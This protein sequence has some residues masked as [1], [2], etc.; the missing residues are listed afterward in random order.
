[1]RQASTKSRSPPWRPAFFC[2]R[3]PWLALLCGGGLWCAGALPVAGCGHVVPDPA[4]LRALSTLSSTTLATLDALMSEV[5][6]FQDPDPEAWRGRADLHF[7]VDAGISPTEWLCS[8]FSP[9]LPPDLHATPRTR[10]LMFDMLLRA[11]VQ[12]TA[13]LNRPGGHFRVKGASLVAGTMPRVA[14]VDLDSQVWIVPDPDFD[15]PL[16]VTHLF[17][18]SFHG[19]G[20]AAEAI[21]QLVGLD[22]QQEIMVDFSPQVVASLSVALDVP[23]VLPVN[24]ASWDPTSTQAVILADVADRGLL[25]C[26]PWAGTHVATA[27]PPCPPWSRAGE[28]DGLGD[29]HGMSFVTALAWARAAAPLALLMEC[30]DGLPEHPHFPIIL[31]LVQWAGYRVHHSLVHDHAT[32]GPCARRRWLATLLRYDVE[33]LAPVPT[34]TF[35]DPVP[36]P[37][38]HQD[39]QVQ[40]APEMDLARLLDDQV[41]RHYTNPAFLP[42]AEPHQHSAQEVLQR[43]LALDDQPLRTLCAR[44]SQQHVLAAATLADRGLFAQLTLVEFS[45]LWLGAVRPL[46]LPPTL[47]EVFHGLGNCISVPQAAIPWTV[48]LSAVGLIAEVPEHLVLRVWRHRLRGVALRPAVVR[49]WYFLGALDQLIDFAFHPQ[50]PVRAD[51]EGPPIVVGDEAFPRM[52]FP[53][54]MGAAR[55]TLHSPSGFSVEVTYPVGAAVSLVLLAA[56]LPPVVLPLLAVSTFARVWLPRESAGDLTGHDLA[57]VPAQEPGQLAPQPPPPVLVPPEGLH[58]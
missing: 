20:Q 3:P 11:P 28:Q 23:C 44:Y 12:F 36:V 53:Y 14:L 22:I 45:L 40:E 21:R 56:R 37:W 25:H 43:R 8:A 57:V 38:T 47:E 9:G 49:G 42:G 2:A 17:A 51:A 50:A 7:R 41:L 19:W 54:R 48:F 29:P 6:F 34:A 18:G 32:F 55:S 30:V 39:F 58:S 46:V 52:V 13:L 15:A 24:L 33:V 1:M 16:A 4:V 31:A 27:S 35:G 5:V 26:V 10:R